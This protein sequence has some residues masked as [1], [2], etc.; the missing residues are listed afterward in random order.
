M[1]HWTKAVWMIVLLVFQLPSTAQAEKYSCSPRLNYVE[2]E[3]DP[4]GMLPER[5]AFET[6]KYPENLQK[7]YAYGKVELLFT[8]TKAGTVRDVQVLESQHPSLE[9]SS[10]SAFLKAKFK[11]AHKAGKPV[12]SCV[13]QTIQFELAPLPATIPPTQIKSQPYTIPPQSLFSEILGEKQAYNV[14]P[15]VKLAVGAVY[16]FDLLKQDRQGTAKV[17]FLVNPKG[18][19]EQAQIMAASQPDFGLATQAMIEAWKFEPAK[20]NGIYVYSALSKDQSFSLQ[21]GDA[22][23]AEFSTSATGLLA[24]SKEKKPKIY[25]LGELDAIPTAIYKV[26]PVYPRSLI[27][28]GI[29]ADAKLEFFLDKEGMVQLPRILTASKPEFGWAA[30]TAVKRWLFEPPMKAGKPVNARLVMPF[31][32]KAPSMA[33]KQLPMPALPT[34]NEP[35]G[36]TKPLKN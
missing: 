20:K 36:L 2:K 16:P 13:S 3:P 8:V 30:A 32:F 29:Q 7:L 5:L 25:P 34:T 4:P 33:T 10:V 1:G 19:V 12:D 18:D 24:E 23:N 28:T 15:T 27:K 35:D 22:D 26:M 17:R 6:P 31:D 21:P 14:P 9:S 11:P